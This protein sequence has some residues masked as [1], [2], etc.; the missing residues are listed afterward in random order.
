MPT[1]AW[2]WA[3]TD[4]RSVITVK[5]SKVKATL[6]SRGNAF[7]F[8]RQKTALTGGLVQQQGHSRP[9]ISGCC[10]PRKMQPSVY[11]GLHWWQ[12]QS[13]TLTPEDRY[14]L[15]NGSRHLQHLQGHS[16]MPRSRW[17][18]GCNEQWGLGRSCSQSLFPGCGSAQVT[19]MECQ[20]PVQGCSFTH[21]ST[22][23]ATLN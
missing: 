8:F 4:K 5:A 18:H 6:I 9:S 2:E 12:S 23:S 20:K 10:G 15:W 3:K 1:S 13:L 22:S 21:P 11:P 19:K 16:P 7:L 14:L 17:C